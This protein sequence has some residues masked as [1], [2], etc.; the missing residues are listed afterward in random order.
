MTDNNLCI[1]GIATT[2]VLTETYL[3]H[4]TL[5]STQLADTPSLV[6]ASIE[7]EVRTYA[8]NLHDLVQHASGLYYFRWI[9]KKANGEG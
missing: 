6:F 2:Y 5:I 9:W 7:K 3:K 4:C 8:Q 1:F